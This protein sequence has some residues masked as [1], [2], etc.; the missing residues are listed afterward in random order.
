MN[1]SPEPAFHEVIHAPVRL[2][3]CGLLRQV[4]EVEFSVVRDTL[5]LRDAHLSK[6]LTV[7]AEADLVRLRK[8]TSPERS[9][10]RR[11]TW[12]A[13]TPDGRAAVE[14]HLAALR[15]IADGE[16]SSLG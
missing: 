4:D 13:L 12:V 3:I 6:N 8:E 1:H 7:L 2:R 9:D 11:L 5:S 15:A 16:P 14:A 10:A